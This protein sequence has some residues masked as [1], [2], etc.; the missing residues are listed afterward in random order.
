MQDQIPRCMNSGKQNWAEGSLNTT[1]L[2]WTKEAVSSYLERDWA[3]FC[4][5]RSMSE[6]CSPSLVPTELRWLSHRIKPLLHLHLGSFLS[7]TAGSLLGLLTPLVLKWLI[8][9]IIPTHRPFL[10]LL[11]M[12]L[13]FAGSEGKT[14]IT[15]LGSYL[16]LN[17]ALRMSLSLR[18]ELLRHLDALSAEYYEKTPVGTVVYPLREPIEEIAYFGS[19]LVPAILRTLLTTGFT[20]ATMLILSP[21]LTVLVAPLIPVFLITRQHFRSKL[22]TDSDLAQRDRMEWSD[23]LEEHIASAIP[24]QLLGQQKRQERR[25]FRFLG[26]SVRSQEKLFRTGVSFTLYTSLAVVLAMTAVIGYGGW[27]VVAGTLSLGSLVAF[28]SL[29]TQLF[30]P[31]SGAAELYSRAQQTFASVRVIQSVLALRPAIVDAPDACP[32]APHKPAMIEFAGVEFGYERQKRML[33]IPSLQIAP[34]ERLAIAGENG[35][36][37]STLTKLVARIYDVD[38]GSVCIGGT[39]LRSIRLDSLRRHV[40]YVPREPVLFDGTVAFNLRFVKPTAYDRELQQAA[41]SAGVFDLIRNLPHGFEQRIGPAGCQLSGGERQRL[42][43]ARAL[44]QR[45]KI[46][47]LDEA[48]SCLDPYSE[49][50]ILENVLSHLRESIVI[51][52]SHRHSTLSLFERRITMSA[53][54]IVSDQKCE[55]SRSSETLI[56]SSSPS[57]AAAN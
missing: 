46:L 7:I 20:L 36:G 1:Q 31:L 48:T 29:V 51:V 27:R 17:A 57:S 43:I 16:M 41:M 53:G 6:G 39:D 14:A 37:K 52:V 12:V 40:C 25:A 19:D 56:S 5:K 22:A 23:F 38:T 21:G 4:P 49:E 33:R 3:P 15:S 35:A 45:P 55:A 11:A 18:M 54:E 47:I 2:S 8:D 32:I 30:E 24:I 42:A 9:Q 26:R 28:Y 34:G 44:L 50:L 10:L 13:I